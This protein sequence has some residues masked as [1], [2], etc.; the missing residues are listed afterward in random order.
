MQKTIGLDVHKKHINAVVI[1]PD[2]NEIEREKVPNYPK[3]LDTFFMAIPKDSKIALESCSCWQ[4]VYDYL[5]DNG[6]TN[7][8]LA[9]PLKVRL[10]ATSRQKTDFK[11]AKALA[12]LLRVNLLPMSWAAPRH[13]RKQRQIARHREGQGRLQSQVKHKIQSILTRHGIIYDFS[14]VFGAEGINYLRSLDLPEV[15]RYEMDQ[16]LELIRHLGVQIKKTETQ[17]EEFVKD[18]PFARIIMTIP[19]I[20]YYSAL[21]IVAEIGDIRRF[22]SVRKLTSFAGLNP[23]VSQSGDKCYTG[24]ISK[25]G[26]KHLRWIL[27][28]C[29]N[30]A[31]LHDSTLAKIYHRIKKRRGHNIAITATARKM[32]T[33]IFAMLTNNI[34]YQALQIHKA[35]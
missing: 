23:S 15:D 6:F 22:S 19:G 10:I 17:I 35:S 29:A 30:V 25:Q 34:T 5:E 20:S 28:Q 32:L 18:N 33:Y 16:H 27:I 12:Q 9:N 3:R 14:D 4:Y 1:D 13:I 11:D 7:V 26:D 31:V 24:H 2:G 21:L 8:S